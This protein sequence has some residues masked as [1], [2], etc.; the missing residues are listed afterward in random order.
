MFMIA[1][2]AT[3][4]A[5]FPNQTGKPVMMPSDRRSGLPH[6]AFRVG[7]SNF[8]AAQEHLKENSVPYDFQDHHNAHSIYFR[9]PDDYCVEIT[10][11]DLE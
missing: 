6:V 1:Q 11:Y 9:D 4:I 5:L 2:D 8:Q 10:T 7:Y 3:G